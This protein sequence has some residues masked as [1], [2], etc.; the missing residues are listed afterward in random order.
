DCN[1]FYF[2][3]GLAL[4]FLT[5]AVPVQLDGNWV[6][7]LWAGEAALLFRIG[8]GRNIGIYEK[9]SYPLMLLAFIRIVHDWISYDRYYG[10]GLTGGYGMGPTD[11][12]LPLL[13]INFL[14][15]LLFI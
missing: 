2:V 13:N 11:E 4:V 6:T 3:S 12:S 15:S 8:R 1:L 7:L 14:S 5:I 10:I 9:L